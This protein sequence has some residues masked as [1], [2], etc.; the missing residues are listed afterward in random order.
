MKVLV[1]AYACSPYDGSERAVGWNWICELDQYHRITVLTSSAYEN[2]IE[3]YKN[4]NPDALKNTKF[5]YVDVPN[6]SWHKEYRLERFYYILWQKQAVRVARELVAKEHFDLVHHVTYV[7]CVLPTYMHELDIPFLLGPVAGGDRIP[8]IINYPMGMKDAIFEKVRRLSQKVFSSTRNFK[9]T[10]EKVGLILVTTEETA[11]LIPSKYQ[12][13]VEIFQA[14][15]LREDLYYPEPAPKPERIPRFL[16]AGRMVYLKGYNLAIQA[17]VNALDMGCEAE[18]TILGNTENN[19]AQ[20]VYKGS[21]KKLCGKYLDKEIKFVSKVEYS[22]MKAFYDDFD[23]L[24]NCG[25]RDSGCFVV[26]E[27]MS[28]SIPVICVDAGGPKVNTT[29]ETA[30]K[31]QPAPLQEMIEHITNSIIDLAQNVDKRE[32]MGITARE[33]ALENFLMEERTKRM[34]KYYERVAKKVN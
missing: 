27:A 8:T 9:K 3:D 17:F 34:N 16:M 6:T 5:V 4:N 30:V 2:D 20:E 23:V 18:L 31:I 10:V 28:R 24:L 1:S 21:L 13:K 32:K 33:Y 26:M 25:L 19:P 12:H 11:K 22:K 15:G 7:T 14:I 29:D